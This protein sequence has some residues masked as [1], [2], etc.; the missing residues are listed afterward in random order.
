[1]KMDVADDISCTT[2]AVADVI[3]PEVFAR[4]A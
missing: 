4:I 3:G 1:M 2:A